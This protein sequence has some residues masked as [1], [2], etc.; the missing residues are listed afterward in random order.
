MRTR[1]LLVVVTAIGAG[2]GVDDA[3]RRCRPPERQDL[4]YTK[5]SLKLASASYSIRRDGTHS[6]PIL[7]DGRPTTA[8]AYSPG[9]GRIAVDVFFDGGSDHLQIIDTDGTVMRTVLT[10]NADIDAI[11]WSPHGRKL[12][13]AGNGRIWI[14]RRDGS[15]LRELPFTKV[16]ERH[17][18]RP[19]SDGSSRGTTIDAMPAGMRRPTSSCSGRQGRT[20]ASW[21]ATRTTAIGHPWVIESRSTDSRKSR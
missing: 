4:E 16:A 6:R 18:G 2:S 9:G 8:A 21:S 13:F 5:Y 1:H 3:G 11:T 20:Y 17:G 7:A 12:A 14:V 15:G 10:R 19:W